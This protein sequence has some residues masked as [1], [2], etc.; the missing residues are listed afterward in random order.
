M[1]LLVIYRC[2]STRYISATKSFDSSEIV[3]L[4]LE[5]I[6]LIHKLPKDTI[7]P[8]GLCRI[9]GLQKEK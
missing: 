2:H 8:W 9:V 1:G 6:H 7:Y 3:R 5:A 4:R